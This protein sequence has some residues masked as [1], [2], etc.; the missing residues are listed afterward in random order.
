MEYKITFSEKIFMYLRGTPVRKL[1]KEL[2]KAEQYNLDLTA[3]QLEAHSLASGDI[4]DLAD[5]MIYALKVG[6]P[7]DSQRAAA[8]QLA[9]QVSD[10]AT[11]LETLREMNDHG[12]TN[13]DAYIFGQNSSK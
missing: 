5:S 3:M 2:K 7:L 12:I 10:G 6:I 1:V 11:L 8:C 13:I 9:L 4:T